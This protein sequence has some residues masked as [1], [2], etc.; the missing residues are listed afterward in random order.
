MHIHA[1]QSIESFNENFV[2][3]NNS[4]STAR[5]LRAGKSIS[6]VAILYSRAVQDVVYLKSPNLLKSSNSIG[7]LYCCQA[8]NTFGFRK[9]ML[10]ITIKC[11]YINIYYIGL[12]LCNC[13]SFTV[14]EGMS[15]MV[16]IRITAFS[17]LLDFI[18]EKIFLAQVESKVMISINYYLYI[19]YIHVYKQMLELINV[20]LAGVHTV[21]CHI[22]PL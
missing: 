8:N 20:S 1:V 12:Y 14:A 13:C 17:G 7:G 22:V 10:N 3:L 4:N 2:E 21:E 19:M 16:Y 9:E 5:T 15:S 18:G 11:R 6:D